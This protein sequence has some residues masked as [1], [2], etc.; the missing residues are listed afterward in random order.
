LANSSHFLSKDAAYVDNTTKTINA[1]V[2]MMEVYVR[3]LRHAQTPET[4][5]AKDACT[6]Y[7]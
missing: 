1:A 5:S 4:D 7:A 2:I 3:E 6:Y